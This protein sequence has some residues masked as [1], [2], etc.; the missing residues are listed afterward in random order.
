MAL[1]TQEKTQLAALV[2][3]EGGWDS[4]RDQLFDAVADERINAGL[5][6]LEGAVTF[7]VTDWTKV[8]AVVNAAAQYRVG[9]NRIMDRI[10]AAVQAGDQNELGKSLV[11]LAAAYKGHRGQ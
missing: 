3:R 9:V 1:T 6:A 10:V 8:R 7:A 5:A 2:Q 11:L 4:A